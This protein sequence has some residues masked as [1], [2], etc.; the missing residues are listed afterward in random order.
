MTMR[1]PTY[2]FRRVVSSGATIAELDGLR[3]VAIVPVV[4]FHALG[5]FLVKGLA[6]GSYT[7]EEASLENGVGWLMS[8]GFL[9]VEL[10]FVISGFVVTLPFARAALA[11]SAAPTLRSFFLRRLTRIEPPYLIA[12]AIYLLASTLAAR[13]HLDPAHYFAGAVYL[14]NALYHDQNWPFF[15]SWSLEIEIQF[16]LLAPLFAMVYRL[17]SAPLRRATL[18]AGIAVFGAYAA[19]ARLVGVEAA[20]LGG[21]L[22]HGRWLGPELAFFLTGM[23]AADLWLAPPRFLIAWTKSLVGRLAWDLL[24]ISGALMVLWSYN[25]LE[26]SAWGIALLLGGLLLMCLGT[27]WSRLVR[28]ALSIPLVSAIGGACYTIYLFQTLF[29]EA[30]GRLLL[31]FTS[32]EFTQ[33]LLLIALPFSAI[34]IACCML[35]F[36]FIE[37]PFMFRRWP[38]MVRAAIKAKSLSPLAGV[39]AKIESR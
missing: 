27:F 11:S 23:L 2:L 31:R 32:G 15:V 39:F 21:P 9:G 7:T 34:T 12:L 33:D 26:H 35:A 5:Y 24:W 22:Q 28:S 29:I 16:Y 18:C 38:S 25:A 1:F 37:R 36:P 17:R 3:A 14:K 20:P 10:F 30:F 13:E 4:L 6:N 8:R 19:N